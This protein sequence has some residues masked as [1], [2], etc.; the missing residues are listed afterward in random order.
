L[1]FAAAAL[2]ADKAAA[3]DLA[4]A[5]DEYE[6]L[7]GAGGQPLQ[8]V[9]TRAAVATHSLFGNVPAL[10]AYEKLLEGD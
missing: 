5:L 3:R 6:M 10:W 4:N 8:E 1:L 2:N 9:C 7:K